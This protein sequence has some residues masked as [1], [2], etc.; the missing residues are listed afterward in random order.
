MMVENAALHSDILSI[1]SPLKIELHCHSL[2]PLVCRKPNPGMPR[3]LLQNGTT[4]CES[5]ATLQNK[6]LLGLQ[7]SKPQR[8]EF[9]FGIDSESDR[10]QTA[11]F[12][13]R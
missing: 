6:P 10:E 5:T 1:E 11:A 3:V 12:L 7:S 13:H 8:H 2:D 4:C 9:L